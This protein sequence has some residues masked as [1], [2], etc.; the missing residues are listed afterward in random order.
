MGTKNRK[1]R[2]FFNWLKAEAFRAR[3]QSA[4]QRLSFHG[5]KE[6]IACRAISVSRKA[7]TQYLVPRWSFPAEM[8]ATLGMSAHS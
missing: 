5:I 8:I 6:A 3:R 4:P 1:L 2:R 7:G